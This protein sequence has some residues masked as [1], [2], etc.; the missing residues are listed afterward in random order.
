MRIG[1]LVEYVE[2]A[3]EFKWLAIVIGD[4]ADEYGTTVVLIQWIT[5]EYIGDRDYMRV[6]HLE[7]IA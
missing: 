5:G 1:D 3:P 4:E 2:E 6:D 7:T